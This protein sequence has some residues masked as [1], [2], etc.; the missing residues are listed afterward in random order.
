MLGVN[1]GYREAG[2]DL[3]DLLSHPFFSLMVA[4]IVD[5]TDNHRSYLLHFIPAEAAGGNSRRTKSEAAG[6]QR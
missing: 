2:A 5:N 6:Y 1:A 4:D 3:A